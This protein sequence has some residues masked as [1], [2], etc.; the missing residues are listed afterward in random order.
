MDSIWHGTERNGMQNKLVSGILGGSGS[1]H[2]QEEER[3]SGVLWLTTGTPAVHCGLM[4]LYY[5]WVA[6]AAAAAAVVKGE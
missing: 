5:D 6:V 2:G 4:E 3:D 1:T